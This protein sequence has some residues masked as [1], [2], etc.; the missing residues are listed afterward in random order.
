TTQAN[1]IWQYAKVNKP[2]FANTNS[3]VL[4]TDSVQ[5]YPINNESSFMFKL[6]YSSNGGGIFS[7]GITLHHKYRTDSL[8]DGLTLEYL[9]R[10]SQ[11][12]KPG[13]DM[14][15]EYLYFVGDSSYN[16]DGFF[17]GDLLGGRVDSLQYA[18]LAF[19]SAVVKGGVDSLILRF[20][21]RSDSIDTH[22]PGWMID[23]IMIE[24]NFFSIGSVHECNLA[25]DSYLAYFDGDRLI[26]N[27]LLQENRQSDF[28]LFDMLGREIIIDEVHYGLNSIDVTNL[29]SGYYIVKIKN[30]AGVYTKKLFIGD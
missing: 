13:R 14:F 30:Q 27:S 8:N 9:D 3:I 11:T 19:G 23:K 2:G 20:T 29:P 7:L 18:R 25:Q 28:T 15:S 4:T 12:W 17:D 26:V 1:N 5:N 22:K 24:Q 10:Y 6:K 16:W 21:F